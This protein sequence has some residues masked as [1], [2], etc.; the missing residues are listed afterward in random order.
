MGLQTTIG[1]Q[2]SSPPSWGSGSLGTHQAPGPWAGRQSGRSRR[3]SPPWGSGAVGG[4]WGPGCGR[5][6]RLGLWPGTGCT[7]V[8]STGHALAPP[9]NGRLGKGGDLVRT[10][11]A[12]VNNRKRSTMNGEPGSVINRP[13]QRNVGAWCGEPVA[14]GTINPVHHPPGSAATMGICHNCIGVIRTWNVVTV[15]SQ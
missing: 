6:T 8:E 1:D 9:P 4:E 11:Q 12:Q 5:S 15:C 7:A 3:E 13:N 14:S 2:S 10:N